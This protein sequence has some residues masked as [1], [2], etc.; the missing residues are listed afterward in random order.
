MAGLTVPSRFIAD[1]Y[2]RVTVVGPQRRVDIAIPANAPIVEYVMTIARLSGE[3]YGDDDSDRGSLPPAWSLA[4]TGSR[5]LPL[6]SSLADAGITDGSVLYLRDAAAGEEDDPVVTD[7]EEAVVEAADRFGRAW[8]PRVRAATEL[9]A[10]AFW[11]AGTVGAFAVV[12]GRLPAAGPRLLSALGIVAAIVSA[13]LAGAARQRS[14]PVSP[15]LRTGLAVA[16]VPLLAA[17]AALLTG[18]GA[19]PPQVAAAAAAGALVGAL[20]GLAACPGPITAGL[21]AAAGLVLIVAGVLV[22][23]R[24]DG[25]E[26][27]GVVAVVAM[28]LYDLAP[29]SVA[30]LVAR[31]GTASQL[32]ADLPTVAAHV[33]QAQGLVFAWQVVLAVL[34]ALAVSWLAGSSQTFAFALA[35]C[36]S[37]GLVLASG[38]YIRATGVIPGAA[39][40]AVGLLGVLLLVPGT[41]SAPW[42]TGPLACAVIGLGL[43]ALGIGHSF[44]A[45]DPAGPD[46]RPSWRTRKEKPS[47][48]PR[49]VAALLRVATIPL[50][51]G[52]FGAF[53]HLITVGRGL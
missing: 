11:L 53:G 16:S 15:W 2:C 47:V 22:A 33:R 20:F 18:A 45:T 21:T 43:L 50:L 37:L 30:A 6:E 31:T 46:V 12:S 36:V 34:A 49:A 42:W 38:G 17:S 9:A 1:Q 35:A 39:A 19:T 8:T 48:W 27:A 41:L 26:C 7:V 3:L 23:L 5:P 32:E 40:G 52:I 4:L 51:V 10:G 13:G 14:W 29:G 25:T 24:A 28:W 44:A